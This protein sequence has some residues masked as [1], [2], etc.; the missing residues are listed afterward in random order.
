MGGS[1]GRQLV[2]YRA[3]REATPTSDRVGLRP[4]MNTERHDA[5]AFAI[6]AD[7][8]ATRTLHAAA[9]GSDTCV[10]GGA[11][12]AAWRARCRMPGSKTRPPRERRM[13][14]AKL[15]R[16]I[17]AVWLGCGVAALNVPPSEEY[18]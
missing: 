3:Y 16:A 8:E 2:R 14:A 9:G 6:P 10:S 1:E 15:A 12:A 5:L 7:L 4:I 18:M 11:C 13:P 17:V